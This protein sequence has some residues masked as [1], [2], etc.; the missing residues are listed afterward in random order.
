MH[1]LMRVDLIGSSI[2]L[3]THLSCASFLARTEVFKEVIQKESTMGN[4]DGRGICEMTRVLREVGVRRLLV[5][6]IDAFGH[7][8]R[9]RESI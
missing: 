6:V 8:N 5:K 2:G 9:I 4:R 7:E 1:C 3:F